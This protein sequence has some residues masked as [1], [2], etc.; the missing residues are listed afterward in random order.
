[1]AQSHS[2]ALSLSSF[3]SREHRV[4]RI[5][6]I[7]GASLLISGLVHLSILVIGGGSWE[8]PL[9]LRKPMTFGLSFGLTLMTIV[10]VSSFLGLGNRPRSLLIGVFTAACV[11]ETALVTLQAWRGVPSHFNLE[12]TVD[13]VVSRT[14]AAGGIVLV[15]IIVAFTFA[16]FRAA[17]TVPMSLRLG[18]RIGFVSLVAAAFVGALMIAKGMRLVFTG[19]S[20]AA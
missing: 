6:Y 17:A 5:G 19:D 13:G 7:V 11:L 2:T 4:E 15:A 8:G 16:S 9:S 18:I 20:A 12:T 3:W 10:W 1:M 14:L